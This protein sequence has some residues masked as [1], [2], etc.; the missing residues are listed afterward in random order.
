MVLGLAFRRQAVVS[1]KPVTAKKC[2][3]DAYDVYEHQSVIYPKILLQKALF[4]H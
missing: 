1:L 3:F 4:Q 2:C